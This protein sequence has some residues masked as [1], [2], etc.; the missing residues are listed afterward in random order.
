MNWTTTQSFKCLGRNGSSEFVV[1]VNSA[2]SRRCEDKQN[3][4]Q[5]CFTQQSCKLN[6][7]DVNVPVVHSPNITSN[8]IQWY[9]VTLLFGDFFMN[10]F[11]HIVVYIYIEY[12]CPFIRLE[13]HY[14]RT[15]TSQLLKSK[16]AVFTRASD[17]TSTR[18]RNIT[19]RLPSYL[20][21]NQRV[22][23]SKLHL[24]HDQVKHFQ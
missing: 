12:I 13:N 14:R 15:I 23:K 2:A 16:T 7:P 4:S 9:K 24:W 17:L 8:G 3:Y 1:T 5:T 18:V 10:I 21:S 6:C 19:W 11:L 22:S 20:M